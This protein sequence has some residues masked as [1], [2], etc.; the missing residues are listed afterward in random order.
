MA[1]TLVGGS[2]VVETAV[3]GGNLTLGTPAGTPT[4]G[5]L[6]VACIGYRSNAT[7]SPPAGEGWTLVATQQS[8]GDTDGTSGIASG[9]MWYKFLTTAADP[10]FAFTRTSGNVA[11]G[12]C[13]RYRY[14]NTS[15][16]FRDGNAATLGSL[17]EP[18]AAS[19]NLTAGDL[20]VYMVSSG[21]ANSVG[22]FDAVTDPATASGTGGPQ[23]GL[24]NGSTQPTTGTWVLRFNSTTGT[25]ADHGL[26]IADAVKTTT[27]ATGTM[28]AVDATGSTRSVSIVAAFIEGSPPAATNVVVNVICNA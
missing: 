15:A 1:W 13:L 8:S 17:G 3:T 11:Q 2:N 25:G 20:I 27:A 24:L 6:L 14:V 5:D 28:S 21:D 16:G 9:G 10:S 18:S 26:A 7:F 12:T 23:V 4:I 22:S 19:L